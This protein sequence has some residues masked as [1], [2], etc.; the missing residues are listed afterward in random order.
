MNTSHIYART[1]GHTANAREVQSICH[2]NHTFVVMV[3]D[4]RRRKCCSS[5]YEVS[6]RRRRSHGGKKNSSN[7]SI[8]ILGFYDFYKGAHQPIQRGNIGFAFLTSF[9]KFSAAI[10]AFSGSFFNPFTFFQREPRFPLIL[11]R[12]GLKVPMGFEPMLPDSKSGVIN[13]YTTGP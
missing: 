8:Q 12:A 3:L 13:P 9:I 2:T 10:P 1:P 7:Q 6:I 11:R 4:M 5:L